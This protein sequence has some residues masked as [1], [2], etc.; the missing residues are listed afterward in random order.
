LHRA[1]LADSPCRDREVKSHFHLDYAGSASAA[2][3]PTDRHAP[4]G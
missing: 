2:V 3:L 4:T 1:L